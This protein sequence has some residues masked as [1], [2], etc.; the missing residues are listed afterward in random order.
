MRRVTIFSV[1]LACVAYGQGTE[2]KAKVTDYPVHGT[3]GEIGIGAEYMVQSVAS[4][5]GSFIADKFLVVNV[6]IFPRSP[7]TISTSVFSLRVNGK[8]TLMA[9]TPSMV[10]A[11]VKYPDWNHQ[12]GVV[13]AAGPVI[14]GRPTPVERFPG[15][16]RPAES[17]LPGPVPRAPTDAT[18]G[19]T[20]AEQLDPSEV[21]NV[22]SLPEGPRKQPVSGYV[23]FPYSGKLTKI[24]KVELL[25][26]F[27]ESQQ[28]LVLLLR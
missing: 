27:D 25:V 23:F 6:A 8:D 19:V 14:I 21:V 7:M 5:R 13:V 26:Q 12:R 11:S 2:T 15:D 16:N 9:Q 3:A 10:A 18:G 20:G 1:V 17:R 22:A 24:K 4:S 28:P